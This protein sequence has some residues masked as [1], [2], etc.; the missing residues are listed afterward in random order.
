MKMRVKMGTVV[1]KMGTVLHLDE[2]PGDYRAAMAMA[3]HAAPKVMCPTEWR[4]LTHLAL[5]QPRRR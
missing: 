1:P 5:Q 2:I 3:L 4:Y